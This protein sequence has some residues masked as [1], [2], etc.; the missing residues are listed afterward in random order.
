[1]SQK[2]AMVALKSVMKELSSCLN[3]AHDSGNVSLYTTITIEL[4]FIPQSSAMHKCYLSHVKSQ[5]VQIQSCVMRGWVDRV[6]EL[7]QKD[8]LMAM[9]II[10]SISS[11]NVF[12]S[13]QTEISM[14][15]LD[16]MVQVLENPLEVEV[17]VGEE[18]EAMLEQVSK[19]GY[20]ILS[21]Y[22]DDL[23]QSGFEKLDTCCLI[24]IR[25]L[26]VGCILYC[27]FVFLSS[28]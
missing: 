9:E 5:G 23:S 24:V 6:Q 7:G 28:S 8:P 17:Y 1:M 18:M 14:I 4:L 19:M 11:M 20:S 13:I 3:A 26:Q 25:L 22:T 10:H 16:M 27:C 15:A 12:T 21:K 2:T